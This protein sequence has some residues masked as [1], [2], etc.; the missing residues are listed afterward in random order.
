MRSRVKDLR[1]WFPSC[2]YTNNHTGSVF[3]SDY[4]ALHTAYGILKEEGFIFIDSRT[5]A[6]TKGKKVARS[7]GDFYLH[8]DVFIDN[9]Q[10]FNAIRKQLRTAVKKAQKRGYAIAIGHPHAA[11]FDTLKKSGDILSAVDVVYIDELLKR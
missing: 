8:R 5:S 1:K 7:Y 9:V 2:T 6:K 4:R 11:T 10:N 3:T